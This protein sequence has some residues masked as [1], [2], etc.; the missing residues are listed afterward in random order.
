MTRAISDQ[1]ELL[2]RSRPSD[3]YERDF[4]R[5]TVEQARAV[6]NGQWD[7]LDWDNL[8]EEIGSVGRNDRRSVKSHLK[9]LLAHLLKCI[10]QPERWTESWD[11]TIRAQRNE[12]VVLLDHSP[13]LRGMPG[14]AFREVYK[15]A[16]FLAHG[17][18]GISED[19][20]PEE[21]PFTVEDALSA[22]FFPGPARASGR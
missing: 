7:D 13:S 15:D 1:A 12:I 6:R 14:E 18:T 20:F 5:W 2:A 21:P 11:H 16:V 3:L 4:Y 17:D 9:V 8:A 22:D 19:G 10:V